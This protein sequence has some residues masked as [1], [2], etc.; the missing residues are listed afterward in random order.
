MVAHVACESLPGNARSRWIGSNRGA[1]S[2]DEE[3]DGREL[4][5]EEGINTEITEGGESGR[6][7]RVVIRGR[8]M[9]LGAGHGERIPPL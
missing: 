4:K 5:V 1:E 3:V 2:G 9:D 8:F 7:A 6:V